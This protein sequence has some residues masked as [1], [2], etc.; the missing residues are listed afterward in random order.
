MSAVSFLGR[1]GYF[2]V[3][4][5][6]EEL[7][8][9][10]YALDQSVI[11]AIT[12]QRGR[13]TFVND[14]FCEI[15]KFSREEL[16][17]QDHRILNSGHHSKL[18]FR[19]MWQR[20][21]SGKVWKGDICNRAK[22]GEL[23]WV[24]TTI[25][26]FLN[27]QGQPYQ[28]ITIRTDVTMQKNIMKIKHMAYHDELTGLPNRR[29]LNT[30]LKAAVVQAA[31]S[32]SKMALLYIDIDR[33]KLINDGFGHSMGDLFLI[34]VAKRLSTIT[35]EE[36]CLFRNNGDEFILLLNDV[37]QVSSTA[38]T[39]MNLFKDSFMVDRYELYATVSIGVSLF[40]KHGESAEDLIRKADIA[41]RESRSTV[42]SKFLIYEP[43]MNTSPE[44]YILET[45]LRKAI[46]EEKMKLHY[47]PKIDAHS[48][49]MVGMEALIRWTDDELG[50]VP[51]NKFI[52]LAEERGLITIIGEWVLETVAKQIKA[53]EER[54]YT[55]V[56]V[57]I[58]ISPVHFNE[59]TFVESVKRI[60][61]ETDVNPTYIELEIT[62]NCMMHHTKEVIQTLT[63]LKEMGITIS[64]DDFGTG[65]SSLNYLQKFPIDT[66]KIDQSFV[67]DLTPEGEGE[68]MVAAI[69][70]LAHALKL[71]VVAE[72]VEREE[73]LHILKKYGCDMIQGYYYSKPLPVDE[74]MDK[75]VDLNA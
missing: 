62:E 2:N 51:P 42:Y 46:R 48:N 37:H 36:E 68:A 15:S 66:L 61:Q 43:E 7:R 10:K 59:S 29:M 65:Y 69:I 67:R 54:N 24:Q 11:V 38:A 72:G 6:L 1:E 40:P 18:F 64:I 12:D 4:Y 45:K 32:N 22:D 8:D 20:I 28:Y 9:I 16:V 50:Y 14:Q 13:I 25:V 57:A 71:H 73:E 21:N 75:M 70:K 52:P 63:Q 60:L 3:D 34:E 5:S 44:E 58:N 19:E 23:Y 49:K 41:L 17:G 27:Q 35:C 39:I 53:W 56:R 74:I 33:F 26:P 30:R 55:I 31:Q 47:Q